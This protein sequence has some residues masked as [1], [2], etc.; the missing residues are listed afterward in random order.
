MHDCG[1]GHFDDQEPGRQGVAVIAI[2]SDLEEVLGI[3]DR[4]AVMREGSVVGVLERPQ[5]SEK[6][7]MSLAFGRKQAEALVAAVETQ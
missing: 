4:I 6:A 5:F 7:V 1:F 3:S 2:S